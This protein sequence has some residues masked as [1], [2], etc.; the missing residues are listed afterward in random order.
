MSCVKYRGH[1][2]TVCIHRGSWSPSK[3]L[4][5]VIPEMPRD[6]PARAAAIKFI[7]RRKCRGRYGCIQSISGLCGAYRPVRVVRNGDSQRW[8]GRFLR[9]HLGAAR[10]R[11]VRGG[12]GRDHRGCQ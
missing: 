10:G 11:A 5:S 6:M 8:H 3:I 12:P 2:P 4:L 1:S 9:R 7:A